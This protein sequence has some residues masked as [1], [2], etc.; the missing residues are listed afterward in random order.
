MD[1]KSKMYHALNFVTC[2]SGV[3]GPNL[4]YDTGYLD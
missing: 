4:D 3:A 2:I 1:M